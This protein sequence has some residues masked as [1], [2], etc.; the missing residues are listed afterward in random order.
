MGGG[1]DFRI[2]PMHEVGALPAGSEQVGESPRV[3]SWMKQEDAVYGSGITGGVA[4]GP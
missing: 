2:A 4:F 1:T 3:P